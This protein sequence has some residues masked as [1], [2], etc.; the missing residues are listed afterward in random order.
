MTMNQNSKHEESPSVNPS[1]GYEPSRVLEPIQEKA[2][3]QEECI[4]QYEDFQVLMND[5]GQAIARY[6]RQRPAV[7]ACTL[8]TA[9]F[10]VGWKIKPW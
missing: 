2:H 4:E 10:L 7:A 9:G 1:I 6:C 3:S 5:I 8:F